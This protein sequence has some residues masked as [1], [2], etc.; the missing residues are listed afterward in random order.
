MQRAVIRYKKHSRKD[1]LLLRSWSFITNLKNWKKTEKGSCAVDCTKGAIMNRKEYF[2][3]LK[4]KGQK[5]R[6][7]AEATADA[8][9][10]FCEQEPEFEQ[11]IEQSDKTF[12]DCLN[13][14]MKSVSSSISDIEVYRRAVKFYFS[15][16][17]VSFVMNI[18]LGGEVNAPK[19]TMSK[20]DTKT[21]SVSLDDLLDF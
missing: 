9:I 7:V 1:M 20:S 21:L 5:E 19:I 11:A 8:L 16:A 12:Q 6:A 13:S 4:I 17:T 15:T 2:D 14:I 18:N 3:T 10:S